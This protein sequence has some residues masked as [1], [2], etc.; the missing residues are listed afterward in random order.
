MAPERF[1]D[2]EPGLLPLE[3]YPP[4][5]RVGRLYR[6]PRLFRPTRQEEAARDLGRDRR[7]RL[8]SVALLGDEG[9]DVTLGVSYLLERQADG[10]ISVTRSEFICVD[11]PTAPVSDH[12][13]FRLSWR[14]D[15]RLREL[16]E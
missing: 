8:G 1:E 13:A 5:V 9:I 7:D 3:W 16:H 14:L 10:A 2:V 6:F 4:T 15:R 12:L 11:R